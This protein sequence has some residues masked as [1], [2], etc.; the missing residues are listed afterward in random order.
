MQTSEGS[1][2]EDQ[3]SFHGYVIG[4][5]LG[6]GEHGVVKEAVHELTGEKVAIKVLEKCSIADRRMMYKV[7]REFAILKKLNHKHIS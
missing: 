3:D 2:K 4:R 5:T 1:D 6:Q 7:K